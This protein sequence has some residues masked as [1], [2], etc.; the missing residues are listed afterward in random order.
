MQPTYATNRGA[1]QYVRQMQTSMKGKIN[2]E[3]QTLS[4]TMDQLD[5]VDIYSTFHPKTMDFTFF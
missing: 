2:K 1:T 4:D 3:T 5:V